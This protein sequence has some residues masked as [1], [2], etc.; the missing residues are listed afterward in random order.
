[1][2]WTPWREYNPPVLD[3]SLQ[4]MGHGRAEGVH[5]SHIL[6]KIKVGLGE[7][8]G[9]VEG[10]QGDVRLIEGFLFEVA[11]EYVS[12]GMP[13]DQAL[14][15][16]FKRYQMEVWAKTHNQVKVERDGIHMTPDAF[17]PVAGELISF[18]VTRRTLRNAATK[19]DFETNF[20]AWVMQEKS[21]AY[22]LGVDTARWVVLWQAGDYGKGV[23]SSPRILECKAVFTPQELA[24]NWRVVLTHA[25]GI[26]TETG[27]Q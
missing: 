2:E 20:W 26:D 1:M 11:I 10:D 13:F 24:D 6:H 19:D 18:K 12:V 9:A 3:A 25:K 4:A 5:L 16:A 14:E 23:G 21:Y 27:K 7:K 8:V 15:L 17:D 22:A